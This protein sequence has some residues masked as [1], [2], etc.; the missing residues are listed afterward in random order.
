MVY[1]ERIKKIINELGK[2][3]TFSM[4][5]NGTLLNEDRIR[6]LNNN[7]CRIA[8][9]YDGEATERDNSKLPQW[10]LCKQIKNLGL[11]AYASKERNVIK[12]Q[13]DIIFLKEKYAISNLK[14][15]VFVRLI[16]ETKNNSFQKL[17]IE[18]E[19]YIR[20]TQEKI[21]NELQLYFLDRRLDDKRTLFNSVVEWL[22]PKSFL[23][24]GC[25][26]CNNKRLTIT[27][28]GRFMICPYENDY[29][30][31]IYKGLDKKKVENKIPQKC[32]VCKISEICKTRCVASVTENECCIS[33][34]MNN[35]LNKLNKQYNIDIMQ[36]I[37]KFH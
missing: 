19:E 23:E 26:C 3:Y 7:N 33:I 17:K 13:K 9:S 11:C 2:K 35:F 22:M 25:I 8:I 27:T 20:S 21:E 28:D 4:V 30:G 14:E 10:N 6:F 37:L 15:S 24:Y 36:L 18:T 34:E 1:Y 16:H 12:I 5:T 32:K 29:C 31:D